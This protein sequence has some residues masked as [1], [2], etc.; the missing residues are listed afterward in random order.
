MNIKLY[1]LLIRLLIAGLVL[2]GF[3]QIFPIVWY[4]PAIRA[5]V[6]TQAGTPVAGAVVVGSWNIEGAMNGATR[7]QLALAEVLTDHEG[8]FRIPAWGP[9]FTWSGSVRETDPTVRIFHPNFS[10]LI[11]RNAVV[12]MRPAP[13]IIHFRYQDQN[14]VLQPLLPSA[15]ERQAA[16]D[17]VVRSLIWVLR[18][19]TAKRCYV[20]KIPL[21][22]E[23]LLHAQ[24]RLEAEGGGKSLDP[25]E[26]Y[27]AQSKHQLCR[28][29]D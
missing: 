10:P 5:R 13:R 2:V 9:R 28:D 29:I 24:Q 16:L 23:E 6:V 19:P 18:P 22:I 21:L 17:N 3:N 12:G 27:F 14:L 7:G 8:W 26:G 20:Q 1:R 11:L 25:I 4:S 15:V